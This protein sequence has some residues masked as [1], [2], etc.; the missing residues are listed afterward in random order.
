M[1]RLPIDGVIY[2]IYMDEIYRGSMLSMDNY[3]IN[4]VPVGSHSFKAHNFI[5]AGL[6]NIKI[7]KNNAKVDFDSRKVVISD[8]SG[9]IE[10]NI[11]EGFNYITIPVF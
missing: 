3:F 2:Y 9:Y 10:Q 1:D 8:C 4:E 7:H 11:T 5:P 6:S